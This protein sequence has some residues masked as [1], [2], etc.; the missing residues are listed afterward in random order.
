M[1]AVLNRTQ[2]KQSDVYYVPVTVTSPIDQ[3]F[4]QLGALKTNAYDF[5]IKSGV[6]QIISQ[7]SGQDYDH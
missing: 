3:L 7:K 1:A 6:C 4:S 2:G 5:A